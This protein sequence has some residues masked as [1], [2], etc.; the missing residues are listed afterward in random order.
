LNNEQ[1]PA[2]KIIPA[3]AP[4][5]IAIKRNTIRIKQ[6]G[7]ASHTGSTMHG[8]NRTKHKM[9]MLT[10]QNGTIVSI[11]R[12]EYQQ[13]HRIRTSNNSTGTNAWYQ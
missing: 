10:T 11:T 9:E 3:M 7:T 4:K 5:P 8:D 6:N 1:I 13:L 2:T 12:I